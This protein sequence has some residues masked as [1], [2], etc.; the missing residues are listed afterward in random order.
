[1]GDDVFKDIKIIDEKISNILKDNGIDSLDALRKAKI[2][3]LTKIKGIKRKVAKQIKKEI[4]NLS[5]ESVDIVSEPFVE[6]EE[7]SIKKDE[8]EWESYDEDKI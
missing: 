8:E 3:D 2:K 4:S 1:M 6:Y 7:P 5:E